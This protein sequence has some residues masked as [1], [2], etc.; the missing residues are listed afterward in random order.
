MTS[1]TGSAY[2]VAASAC[3]AC[4]SGVCAAC[5]EG[6]EI[7]EPQLAEAIVGQRPQ[8]VRG[9]DRGILD[10][11]P[12]SGTWQTSGPWTSRQWSW[13]SSMVSPGWRATM[14]TALT[15][16]WAAS[17]RPGAPPRSRRRCSVADRSASRLTDRTVGRRRARRSRRPSVLSGRRSAATRRTSRMPHGVLPGSPPRASATRRV[18]H[19]V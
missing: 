2:S 9:R 1:P 13:N 8:G 4:H 11:A 14:Y 18:D 3:T 6:G 7:V 12:Q 16:P 15:I 5:S 17:D 19:V 10:V